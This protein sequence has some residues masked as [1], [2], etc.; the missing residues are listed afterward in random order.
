MSS[1]STPSPDKTTLSPS[2]LRCLP[3]EYYCSQA[4]GLP[5]VT[6]K[7]CPSTQT[8]LTSPHASG[9]PHTE[10]KIYTS[11]RDYASNSTRVTDQRK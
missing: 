3:C 1:L 11:F 9:H 2:G 8:P 4:L 10:Y 6:L 7:Y 5:N